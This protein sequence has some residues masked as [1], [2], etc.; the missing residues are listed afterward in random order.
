MIHNPVRPVADAEIIIETQGRRAIHLIKSPIRLANVEDLAA[1]IWIAD[2]A[3]RFAVTVSGLVC[4]RRRRRRLCNVLASFG[5]FIIV[6]PD[7]KASTKTGM[8]LLPYIVVVNRR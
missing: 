4:L 7:E 1:K 8:N 2:H 5:R 3:W 6:V